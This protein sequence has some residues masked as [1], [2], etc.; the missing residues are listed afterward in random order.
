MP[1]AA[2]FWWKTP[3]PARFDGPECEALLAALRECLSP[4]G[5]AQVAALLQ[6]GGRPFMQEAKPWHHEAQWLGDLIVKKALSPEIFNALA[7]EIGL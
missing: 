2:T 4:E 3:Q 6:G 7:D 1:P 5:A